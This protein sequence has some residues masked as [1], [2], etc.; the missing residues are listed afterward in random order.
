MSS[1][2]TLTRRTLDEK[3]AILNFYAAQL[4]FRNV[5]NYEAAQ[6]ACES[7]FGEPDALESYTA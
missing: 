6:K 1:S 4:G 7:R 5:E 3:K 2:I